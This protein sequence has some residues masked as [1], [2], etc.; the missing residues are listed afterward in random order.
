M[1]RVFASKQFLLFLLTG[2]FAAV[3]NFISR[4]VY[5]QW[6]SYSTSIFLAYLSGMATAFVLARK[7]VFPDFK[8]GWRRSAVIFSVVNLAAVAQTWAVS[9]GL[10]L[11]VFPRVG[12]TKFAPELAHAVGVVV[13][14][15]TSYLGH[16]YWSF[17]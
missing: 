10:A 13:P 3:V 8:R 12:V 5:D 16:K 15:F 6:L 1:I 9:M 4:L 7:V 2:G 11:F 14:V 17:R